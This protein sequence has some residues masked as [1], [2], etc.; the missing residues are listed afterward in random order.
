VRYGDTLKNIATGKYKVVVTDKITGFV[1][2][3]SIW[4]YEPG[5]NLN[6]TISIDTLVCLDSSTARLRCSVTGGT[7]F[8][9]YKWNNNA[10]L[11]SSVLLKVPAGTHSVIVTD[12]RGCT[13]TAEATVVNPARWSFSIS[14]NNV[15]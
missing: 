10:K 12:R 2:I 4:V 9:K 11:D 5:A 1:R 13:D 3:D 15:A 7:K 8:Y 6:A 14:R